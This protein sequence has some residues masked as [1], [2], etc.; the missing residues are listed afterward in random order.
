MGA[1][2]QGL[3]VFTSEEIYRYLSWIFALILI[4][5]AR[6]IRKTIK[7]EDEQSGGQLDRTVNADV[8]L[9]ARTLMSLNRL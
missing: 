5:L 8:M 7:L 6:N 1:R 9:V 4:L 3:V 2:L